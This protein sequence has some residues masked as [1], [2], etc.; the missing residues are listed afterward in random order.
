MGKA[1][2]TWSLQHLLRNIHQRNNSLFTMD[3]YNSF[4]TLTIFYIHANA[5]LLLVQFYKSLHNFTQLFKIWKLY[6]SGLVHIFNYWTVVNVLL[7][8]SLIML[9]ARSSYLKMGLNLA[10]LADSF[11]HPFRDNFIGMMLSHNIL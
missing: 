10:S 7:L 11:Q 6:K 2:A 8:L 5:D 3:L 9:S 1:L 4:I